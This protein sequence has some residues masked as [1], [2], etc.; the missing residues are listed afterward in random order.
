MYKVASDEGVKEM[1]PT[2][3][4]IRYVL[5]EIESLMLK[6]RKAFDS[7]NKR[8]TLLP[9][10]MAVHLMMQMLSDEEPRRIYYEIHARAKEPK[11]FEQLIYFLDRYDSDMQLTYEMIY[12]IWLLSFNKRF[13]QLFYVDKVSDMKTFSLLHFILKNTNTEKVIRITISLFRNLVTSE[14][15]KLLTCLVRLG[16]PKTLDN[17][18]HGSFQDEDIMTEVN[19]LVEELEEYIE[20]ISSFDEYRQEVVSNRLCWTPV[21]KSEKFWRENIKKFAEGDYILIRMLTA[22]LVAAAADAADVSE[23]A[24]PED[25]SLPTMESLNVPEITTTLDPTVIGIACHDIGQFVS[26]HPRGKKILEKFGTKFLIYQLME[27]PSDT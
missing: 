3:A 25:A 19:K 1:K 8:E 22:M 21:H 13:A 15:A 5:T 16:V 4:H 23:E 12:C 10:R 6:L 17:F 20:Q 26:F 7:T 14:S 24:L 2:E 27:H 11:N 9:L 18:A